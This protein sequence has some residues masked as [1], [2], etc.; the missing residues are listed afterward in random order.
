[1]L[2]IHKDTS[3]HSAEPIFSTSPLHKCFHLHISLALTSSSC[4]FTSGLGL[5]CFVLGFFLRVC[6]FFVSSPSHSAGLPSLSE[7]SAFLGGGQTMAT[8]AKFACWKDQLFLSVL[9]KKRKK[10]LLIPRGPT[11]CSGHLY[12][13]ENYD[14]TGVNSEKQQRLIPLQLPC[15]CSAPD[16]N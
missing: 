9:K 12:S 11:F 1:M 13:H 6:V 15:S 16:N 7:A 14:V 4:F 2:L 8:E 10:L 3:A 5:V